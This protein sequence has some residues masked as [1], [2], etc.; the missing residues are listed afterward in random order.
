[1]SGVQMGE[2]ADRVVQ[3]RHVGGF[4]VFPI[5]DVGLDVQDLRFIA[6]YFMAFFVCM[7]G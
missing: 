4:L 3:Q 6:T 2:M 5:C 1:M 7:L